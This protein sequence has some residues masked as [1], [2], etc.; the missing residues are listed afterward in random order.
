MTYVDHDPRA[1]GRAA[2]HRVLDRLGGDTGPA[3]DIFVDTALVPRGSG[4]IE[5]SGVS[6]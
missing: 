6:S 5:M 1:I 3:R 4:E 2:M